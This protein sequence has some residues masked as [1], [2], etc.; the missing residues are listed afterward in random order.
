MFYLLLL[1]YEI[2]KKSGSEGVW[3]KPWTWFMCVPLRAAQAFPF[4]EELCW[5]SSFWYEHF[6]LYSVISAKSKAIVRAGLERLQSP[7]LKDLL[8]GIGTW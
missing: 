6:M 5:K 8:A 4:R 1:Q 3:M 7:R 2:V